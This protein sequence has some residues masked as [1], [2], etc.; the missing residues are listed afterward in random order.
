MREGCV[1]EEGCETR[2]AA[3]SSTPSLTT[4]WIRSMALLIWQNTVSLFSLAD[5]QSGWRK[6]VCKTAEQLVYIYLPITLIASFVSDAFLSNLLR[7]LSF[8]QNNCIISVTLRLFAVKKKAPLE[9]RVYN[10][11]VHAP[12]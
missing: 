4:K 5:G 1:A 7:V 2:A 10:L 6:Q 9:K 11:K 3:E 12:F 8:D